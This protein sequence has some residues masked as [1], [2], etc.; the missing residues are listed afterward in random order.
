[1]HKINM[2]YE[3][4][5]RRC[6][7]RAAHPVRRS[8]GASSIGFAAACVAGALFGYMVYLVCF[9]FIPPTNPLATLMSTVGMLLLVDEIIVHTTDG[10]P[11]NYPALFGD[12]ML[13]IGEFRFRGDLLFVFLLC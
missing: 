5:R 3:G 11:Q 9:R 2:A 10:M 8:G 7:C 12:V 1:M 13:R 4:L 6:L